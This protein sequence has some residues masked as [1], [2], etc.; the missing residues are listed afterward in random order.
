MKKIL[1]LCLSACI[2]FSGCATLDELSQ[3]ANITDAEAQEYQ[4]IKGD[5]ACLV[6]GE[7]IKTANK[8]VEYLIK[9]NPRFKQYGSLDTIYM[10]GDYPTQFGRYRYDDKLRQ[11]DLCFEKLTADFYDTLVKKHCD[12]AISIFTE[13]LGTPK[14]NKCPAFLQL[15]NGF[16]Y[17]LAEWNLDKKTIHIGVVSM[18]FKYY[19]KVEIIDTELTAKME[20]EIKAQKQ[21]S[22][23][24]TVSDF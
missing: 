2:V 19:C 15:R 18:S 1:S 12:Y 11:I 13:K 5:F 6:L 23:A 20:A 4:N 21:E 10:F 16:F 24:G 17:L 8:K 14:S 22:R 9:N 7:D 3:D